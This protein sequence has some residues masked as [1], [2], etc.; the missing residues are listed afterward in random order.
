MADA[1]FTRAEFIVA[2]SQLKPAH[3]AARAK[4]SAAIR[5]AQDKK[6][7][8][9]GLRRQEIEVRAREIH[10]IGELPKWTP[11]WKVKIAILAVVVATSL[12]FYLFPDY[13]YLQIIAFLRRILP[14]Y[15]YKRIT[16]KFQD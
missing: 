4:D 12:V 7:S 1:D 15:D 14:N 6:T 9:D 2:T 16:P 11:Y 13:T 8:N 3:D 10:N 5:A